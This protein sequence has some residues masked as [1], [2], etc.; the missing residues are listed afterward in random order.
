VKICDPAVGSGHFLVS[1]LNQMIVIKHELNV[2]VEDR[3]VDRWKKL[4]GVDI[5]IVNDELSIQV[6]ETNFQYNP[7][8]PQS[9]T[10]QKALF[11]EKQIIIENCLFGVDINPNSVKI[12]RL[13][14][15]IE[16]L[17][18]AYY[19]E[20]TLASS[21]KIKVLETLPN[22]D[23]NIKCGNSLIS[24]FTLNADLKEALKKSKLKIDDYKRAVDQYRN[25][26][27]KEQKRDMEVLIE[28]IKSNFKSS[29]EGKFRD[30]ITTII[31]QYNTEKNRLD[32][33]LQL[34]GSLKKE[35]KEKL[36][37]LKINADKASKE[38]EETVNN[39]IYENAFEWRFEFPEVL[40]DDG[41]FAGFDV[42]I[43]N[44]PYLLVF[45]NKIKDYLNSKYPEIKQNYDLYVTFIIQGN[46][47]IKS[48]G[49]FSFITPNTFLK[50]STFENLRNYIIN[51]FQ[52]NEIIDFG[53]ELVFEDASV[54]CSIINCSKSKQI[55]DWFLKSSIYETKG[56]INFDST[57]FILT[58]DLV[59]KLNNF[60]KLEDYFLVKDVGFNYWSEGRGKVRGD[61]IGSRVFYKGKKL[62]ELDL[63]YIKGS[64]INKYSIS[65]SDNFLLNNWKDYLNENDTFR[66]SEDLLKSKEKIVYRQ[67]SNQIIAS[68]DT[69]QNLCDKTVHIIINKENNISLRYL[70]S[71]LNSKLINYYFKSY[72]EEEGRA[73][74]QVKTVDIKN[75]PF[76]FEEEY[77]FSLDNKVNQILSLKKDNPE[78][79]TTALEKEIDA[80]VYALYGLTK[81]EIE[82][83]EGI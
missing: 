76:V 39:K 66:F 12:C 74:A 61:S 8:S 22:I 31:E 78:A 2:L 53:N 65:S 37:K 38:K 55:N 54:F 23:I 35:E 77:A 3:N 44:P 73:F 57:E 32:M 50:G 60:K 24:R 10:I 18:N 48:N 30:K 14:L 28:E 80:I 52:I 34:H 81:E 64:N 1:A 72:K 33:M 46:R 43:G 11:E 36:K 20:I 83:V 16:L 25:A 71:I 45:D 7:K 70:L 9:Q 21:E 47:I 59:K 82:I 13:R 29:F 40:N 17:K 79:D 51:N 56:K 49:Q 62:N 5:K 67:T 69:N 42:V 4:R 41:D 6:D 63:S 75:L 26:E 58:S 27:S 15:W 19:K 68:L